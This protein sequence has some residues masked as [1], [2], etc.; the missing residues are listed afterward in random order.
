M[1]PEARRP[2]PKRFSLKSPRREGEVGSCGVWYLGLG[3][4]WQEGQSWGNDVL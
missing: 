4:L 3:V 1:S 2:V